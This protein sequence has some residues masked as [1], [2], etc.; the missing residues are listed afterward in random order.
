MNNSITIQKLRTAETA[1]LE[2]INRLVLQLNSRYALELAM[3]E[4]QN[5]LKL[6]TIFVARTGSG[7]IIGVVL[8]N[9]SYVLTGSRA[10][11][12]NLV[13]DADFRQRGIAKQ[14]VQSVINEAKRL[15]V[16]TLKLSTGSE[17]VAANSLYQQFGFELWTVNTYVLKLVA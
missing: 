4:L 8:L 6:N 9:V 12:E 10:F 14:L 1:D 3:G 11:L 13:V 15:G 17:N 7:I 5:L 16:N 2:S